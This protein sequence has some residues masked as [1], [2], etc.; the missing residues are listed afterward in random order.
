MGSLSGLGFF[1]CSPASTMHSPHFSM[2]DLLQWVV[3]GCTALLA[4]APSAHLSKPF[5]QSVCVQA[6]VG[7]LD[8]STLRMCL[9]MFRLGG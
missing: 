7:W 1:C 2:G 3:L 9:Y 8:T 4:C 6:T 5:M